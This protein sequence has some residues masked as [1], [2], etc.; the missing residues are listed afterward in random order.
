MIKKLILSAAVLAAL[1]SARETQAAGPASFARVLASSP[2]LH[3]QVAGSRSLERHDGADDS[4]LTLDFDKRN[5]LLRVNSAINAT[6]SGMDGYFDILAGAP[7][8]E[9][10]AGN[11]FDCA[12][13]KRDQL[14]ELGW[15]E[16]AMKIAYSINGEGRIER[17]LVIA[18]DRGDVVLGNESPIVD[19][20]G[21]TAPRLIR[22]QQSAPAAA[23]YDI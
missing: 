10:N 5:E 1:I 8:A 13:M 23:Y 22:E 11:C 19:M 7:A 20:S 9:Q 4:V 16:K 3:T 18:T 21:G 17:V 14:V 15:A 2:I 6:I 12:D